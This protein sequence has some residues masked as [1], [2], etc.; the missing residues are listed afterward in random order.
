[1]THLC[2]GN[3]KPILN[4]PALAWQRGGTSLIEVKGGRNARVIFSVVKQE[5]PASFV[6]EQASRQQQNSL[7]DFSLNS[8]SI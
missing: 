5:L 6:L 8:L 3:P 4:T 7:T 2:Q 1:V